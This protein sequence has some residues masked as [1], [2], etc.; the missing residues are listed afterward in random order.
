MNYDL[1]TG[2]PSGVLFRFTLP[3]FGSMLLQQLYNIVDSLVAGKF[4]SQQALAAVSDSFEVTLIYLAFAF[5]CNIGCS[6]V[7]SQLFGAGRKRDLK[8]AVHTTFLFTAALCAVLMTAGLLAGE[9]LLIAIDTPQTVL[10]DAVD[11]LHIYTLGLIPLFFYNISTGIFSAL[12]DSRTP[13]RFLAVSS[14]ANI[15]MD[16]LFVAVFKLG[17]PGVAWAT[18][19]CQTVSCVLAVITLFR[20]LRSMGE[21]K[22]DLF[23]F[24]LFKRIVSMAI[25]GTLQQSFISVGNLF[26][27]KSING[28]FTDELLAHAMMAGYGAAMKLNMLTI[29]CLSTVANGVSN[30]TGQNIGARKQDRVRA[31]CRAAIGIALGFALLFTFLYLVFG[32]ALV[33]LFLESDSGE[34][35]LEIGR[36]FLLIV[37]P[38]YGVVAIK[39]V[40]DGVFRGAGA[41]RYFTATTFTDLILRV[42]LAFLLPAY[43]D[44]VTGANIWMAWPIGWGVSCLMGTFFYFRG[45]WKQS[46]MTL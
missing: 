33:G 25:P 10:R 1:T 15:G 12:G 4:I 40:F 29:N 7:V 42:G 16:V 2:K 43:I 19:L 32:K 24:P 41:T 30:F 22:G 13:F 11:Y 44:S 5:G 27:Q 31:G 6:V 38:F 28:Y 20:R 14:V 23:S 36:M 8:T 18:F 35:A 46:G 34:K 39:L 9:N 17:V 45:R 21:E 3:L 26:I 37:S